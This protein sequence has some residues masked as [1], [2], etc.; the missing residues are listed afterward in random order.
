MTTSLFSRDFLTWHWIILKYSVNYAS[1]FGTQ[2]WFPHDVDI[3]SNISST[4][5]ARKKST[6]KAVNFLMSR[7]CYMVVDAHKIYF[8]KALIILKRTFFCM[9]LV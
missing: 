5:T 8:D 6:R 7:C 4:W 9:L 2:T 1:N 3:A